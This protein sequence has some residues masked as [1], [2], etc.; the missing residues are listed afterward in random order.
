MCLATAATLHLA[1]SLAYDLAGVDAALHEV[2]TCRDG[3]L[4]L[5][6]VYAADNDEQ[7]L[8]LLLT[9]HEHDVLDCRRCYREQCADVT[10]AVLLLDLLQEIVLHHGSLLLCVLLDLLLELGVLGDRLRDCCLEVR[11]VVEECVNLLHQVLCLVEVVLK[12]LACDS[13]DTAYTCCN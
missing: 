5:L 9:Q 4:W 8:G 13:L 12:S 7:V 1:C 2:V 6:V 10:H 11:Y 3:E